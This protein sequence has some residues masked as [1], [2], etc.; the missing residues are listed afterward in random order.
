MQE[1]T[2]Y[3]QEIDI[4]FIRLREG[5]VARTLERPNEIYVDVDADGQPLSIE[6]IGL[7]ETPAKAV[8]DVFQEFGVTFTAGKVA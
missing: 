1:Q 5:A 7:S 8:M 2:Q 3:H 4:L 6:V